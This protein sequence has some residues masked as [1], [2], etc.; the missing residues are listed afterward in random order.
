MIECTDVHFGYDAR[1]PL[2]TG[3]SLSLRQPG[4]IGLLGLNG[5]GKTS[6]LHL[7]CGLRF[8]AKGTCSLDGLLPASRSAPL[9]EQIG[10]VPE[11]VVLPPLS[12]P[13]WLDTRAPFYS[14]FDRTLFL[15]LLEDFALHI[16]GKLAD[17]SLGAQ[18]KV[19][20]SF[21]LASRA[22]FLF[23]DEPTNGL[24]IP[25]KVALR[26]MWARYLPDDAF[27]LLSTHQVREL[28]TQLDQLLLLQGGHL[29]LNVSVESL[30]QRLLCSRQPER[31]G[32]DALYWERTAAGYWCIFPAGYPLPVPD[33]LDLE[34][35][36][37]AAFER[38]DFVKF[39][40]RTHHA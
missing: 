19:M 3:L 30:E 24:D 22:R 35:V 27:L 11:T 4:I 7:L 18:K 36:C 25:A 23:F 16:P 40:N 26:K 15:T 10:F 17:L 20:L 9:L 39:L 1:H 31:P 28:G 13:A 5:A 12:L 38:P 6:L 8:P 34:M 33:D 2:F 14:S 37:K 29:A 21:C 32:P